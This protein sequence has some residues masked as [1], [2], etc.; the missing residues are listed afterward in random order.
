MKPR[1]NGL[2]KPTITVLM[3]VYNAEHFVAQA[4]G[5]VLE[6]TFEDFEFLIFEDKSTDS[7]REILRS[8]SDGRIRLIENTE[9]LGL[10]KNLALG[11]EMARGE[12]VAR[13]DADDICMP[14]RLATQVSHMLEHPEISVLGSAVTF[15]DGS[16]KEFVAH[17]PLEHDEIKCTLFYGFTMLH[18]SV[19]IRRAEFE[20]HGLNYDPAF[21]VSQDHDLWTRAIRKVRFANIHEPLLGMR[22]HQ[23]KIGRTSKPRQQ[24]L[25]DLV[26]KRQLHELG[27]EA[28]EQEIGVF[29]VEPA[30]QSKWCLNDLKIYEALLLKII[31][32]NRRASVFNQKVLEQMGAAFFR[33]GCRELLVHE[34]NAGQYYWRSRVKQFDD[35]TFRQ[36]V[37]L[38]FRSIRRLIASKS[39]PKSRFQ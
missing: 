13:M 4:I 34:N 18:P 31:E 1:I 27:I 3:S 5:S 2:K 6:Q 14:H 38:A 21:R 12:F 11:M 33:A 30:T 36:S 22:E 26:R 29:N 10:T 20:K 32:A 15:F 17:Q 24:E 35:P 8:F 39:N 7:S 37:G 23:G 16:G 25:S 9:N 19:M 28:T